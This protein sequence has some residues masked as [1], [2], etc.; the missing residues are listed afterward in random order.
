M[1]NAARG[2]QRT[3][4]MW[5]QW[6]DF[7]INALDLSF[8]SIR[9]S[10][11]CSLAKCLLSSSTRIPH[12]ESLSGRFVPF[13]CFFHG[14]EN[15]AERQ[16]RLPRCPGTSPNCNPIPLFIKK[17]E[18]AERGRHWADSLI[19][20]LL[21]DNSANLIH[22][23]H[24]NLAAMSPTPFHLLHPLP[25]ESCTHTHTHTQAYLAH[26]RS[27]SLFSLPRS[28]NTHTQIITAHLWPLYRVSVLILISLLNAEHNHRDP[29]DLQLALWLSSPR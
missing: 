13:L 22:L 9:S 12:P 25:C 28:R 19:V 24:L 17:R 4:T 20:M 14:A 15:A 6:T 16:G 27:L 18:R 5:F 1:Q 29:Q 10:T 2:E 23:F 7:E 26:T 11:P 8:F 21:S 3:L